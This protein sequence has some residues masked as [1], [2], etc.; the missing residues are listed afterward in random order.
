MKDAVCAVLMICVALFVGVLTV[1]GSL[2]FCHVYNL[3][4]VWELILCGTMVPVVMV[5]I[6]SLYFNRGWM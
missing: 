5:A 4:P 2:F 6:L 3:G 1:F